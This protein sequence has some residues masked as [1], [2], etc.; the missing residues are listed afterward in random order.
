MDP[1]ALYLDLRD[2]L[3]T[4]YGQDQNSKSRKEYGF[5]VE[6]LVLVWF[7]S[8]HVTVEIM[9]REMLFI[10]SQHEMCRKY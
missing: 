5:H 3:R 7:I 10:L 9:D 2:R 8:T 6:D 1:E 4:S